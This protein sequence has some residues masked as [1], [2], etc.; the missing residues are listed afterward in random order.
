MPIT[1]AV[2][3]YETNNKGEVKQS[4][5]PTVIAGDGSVYTSIRELSLW[6]KALRNQTVITR[7]SQELA[8]TNGRYDIRKRI[9]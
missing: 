8:W 7:S 2:K 3:G 4:S 1:T 9:A 6:D 5:S